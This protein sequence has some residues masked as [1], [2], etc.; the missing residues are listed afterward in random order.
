MIRSLPSLGKVYVA[1]SLGLSGGEGCNST[2]SG[3]LDEKKTCETGSQKDRN[4]SNCQSFSSSYEDVESIGVL[5]LPF[6]LFSPSSFCT[7]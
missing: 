7:N 6:L 1:A 4:D 3:R 2:T 5:S